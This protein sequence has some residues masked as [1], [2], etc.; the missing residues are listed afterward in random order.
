M[1]FFLKSSVCHPPKRQV[2]LLDLGI[3]YCSEPGLAW[4]SVPPDAGSLIS[5]PRVIGAP[6]PCRRTR[7]QCQ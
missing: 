2:D 7:N 3:G 6:Q 5:P 4:V 1:A